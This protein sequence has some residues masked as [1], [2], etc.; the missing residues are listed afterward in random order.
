MTRHRPVERDLHTAAL[1]AEH[2]NLLHV[3]SKSPADGKTELVDVEALRD[4]EV[5]DRKDGD[6]EFRQNRSEVRGQS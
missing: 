2:P 6:G 1:D 3:V 5:F 4:V